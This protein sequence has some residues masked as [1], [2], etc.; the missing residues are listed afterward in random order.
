MAKKANFIAFEPGQDLKK[1]DLDT[2]T[3]LTKKADLIFCNNTEY[4]Q[5][6]KIITIPDD[7][8]IIVTVGSR[9]SN[10]Y[11]SNIKIPAIP[12]KSVDPTGAGDAFKAGFWAAYVREY[13][14][15]EC[16]K[17]ATTVASF[18]VEKV[19]AQCIP[20]WETTMKRYSKYF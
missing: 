1:Y 19:G 4:N 14:I 16:C 3:Y 10:I 5:L 8:M 15:E 13:D 17:I 20:T 9:G 7:S 12:I 18:V 6:K 2:L 11:N